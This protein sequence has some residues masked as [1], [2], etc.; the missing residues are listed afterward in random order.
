MGIRR[1]LSVGQAADYIGV[2]TSSI[3][4]W[5]DSGLVQVYR[6]PGG[7]R[8]FS[9]DDLDELIRVPHPPN[10]HRSVLMRAGGRD[11]RGSST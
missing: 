4:N 6:T 1:M 9:T 3:R 8:R 10:R 5:S 11:R 2:S 7:D